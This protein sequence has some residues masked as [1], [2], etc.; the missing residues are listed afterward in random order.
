MIREVPR[1]DKKGPPFKIM[2]TGFSTFN[3]LQAVSL[4]TIGVTPYAPLQNLSGSASSTSPFNN[5]S[6]N[7]WK[8]SLSPTNPTISNE[9][10]FPAPSCQLNFEV[11]QRYPC[12]KSERST[13]IAILSTYGFFN[14]SCL[15]GI[16]SSRQSSTS[17][18][19]RFSVFTPTSAFCK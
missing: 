5:S 15:Y 13:P 8:K 10:T 11:S 19:T 7:V 6:P 18:T 12:K 9:S 1:P 4:M 17:T 14:T 16:D 3:I 2:P